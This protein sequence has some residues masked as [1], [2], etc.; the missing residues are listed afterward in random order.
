[1]TG[2]LWE[3]E[4]LLGFLGML[5]IQKTFRCFVW[6]NTGDKSSED[7]ITSPDYH[8]TD[9]L[10]AARLPGES[11]S[12]ACSKTLNGT[13]H[14]KTQLRNYWNLRLFFLMR[15]RFAGQ[16]I[17]NEFLLSKMS[18]NSSRS[19][20]RERHTVRYHRLMAA[21]LSASAP[22]AG[23]LSLYVTALCWSSLSVRYRPL[24]AVSLSALA[25][26]VGQM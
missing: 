13:C 19:R 21:S 20:S 1:M 6:I 16:P 18:V 23:R 11:R 8:W 24:L 9:V 4:L 15:R 7:L 14:N 22:S 5:L 10:K 26:S 2:C 25:P 17:T 12:V 3:G